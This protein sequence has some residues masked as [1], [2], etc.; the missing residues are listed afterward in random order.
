MNRVEQDT[1]IDKS[2]A[3]L[4]FMVFV[5]PLLVLQIVRKSV[6]F[7][8]YLLQC[9]FYKEKKIELIKELVLLSE[10]EVSSLAAGYICY[11]VFYKEKKFL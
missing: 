11:N 5:S 6:P 8:G 4:F 9:F 1:R 7:A 2:N 3:V 10:K